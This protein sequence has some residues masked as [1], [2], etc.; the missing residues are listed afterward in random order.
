MRI[1]ESEEELEYETK[2]A[3]YK[4]MGIELSPETDPSYATATVAVP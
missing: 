2:K 4:L 3:D 1:A